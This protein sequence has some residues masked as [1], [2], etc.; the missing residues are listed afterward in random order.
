MSRRLKTG[1]LLGAIAIL[2]GVGVLIWS[3]LA[4]TIHPSGDIGYGDIAVGT[5]I[6]A[7]VTFA[8]V[9]LGLQALRD[10][11]RA[12][13]PF[14]SWSR[15]SAASHRSADHGV[16]TGRFSGGGRTRRTEA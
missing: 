16:S 14:R 8:S 10:T 9:V 7:V 12:T 1:L 15:A 6:L 5:L 3:A 11:T 13:D 2:A 4:H